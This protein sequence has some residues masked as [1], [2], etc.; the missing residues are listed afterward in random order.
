MQRFLRS[1]SGAA[2]LKV[3]Q[4][5]RQITCLTRYVSLGCGLALNCVRI[6]WVGSSSGNRRFQ[7][8]LA[9]RSHLSTANKDLVRP[10]E[11][12]AEQKAASEHF[13]PVPTI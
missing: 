6:L 2:L 5:L 7:G 8:T 12:N 1:S 9:R 4:M 10:Q 3:S 13:L 11:T